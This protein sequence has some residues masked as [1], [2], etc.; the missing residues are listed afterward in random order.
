MSDNNYVIY[1][2]IT[3]MKLFHTYN[4]AQNINLKLTISEKKK[5]GKV[6]VINKCLKY[7]PE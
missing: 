5:A 6:L 3:Y 1:R 4:K 7:W 2:D